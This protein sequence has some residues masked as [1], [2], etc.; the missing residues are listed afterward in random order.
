[1]Y[2]TQDMPEIQ[3]LPDARSPNSGPAQPPKSAFYDSAYSSGNTNIVPIRRTQNT[4]HK[5]IQNGC[6]NCKR[7]NLACDV[8]RPCMSCVVSG[9][10]VRKL[11]SQSHHQY[12]DNL[13]GHMLRRT[14][15]KTRPTQAKRCI[16]SRRTTS[17]ATRSQSRVQ[18]VVPSHT[19]AVHPEDWESGAIRDQLERRTSPTT[20]NPRGHSRQDSIT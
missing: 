1:M 10:E 15:Q 19:S 11:C 20:H 2:R 12:F 16:L 6:V 17:N 7:H 4:S 5:R 18:R 14:T 3:D 13:E 8:Q 9:K